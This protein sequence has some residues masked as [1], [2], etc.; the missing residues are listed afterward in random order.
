MCVS[1]T[2]Y[3]NHRDRPDRGSMSLDHAR[4][5]MSTGTDLAGPSVIVGEEESG[6][7]QAVEGPRR[8][9]GEGLGTHDRDDVTALT[10][11]QMELIRCKPPTKSRG[12]GGRAREWPYV[13]EIKSRTVPPVSTFNLHNHCAFP[14]A[15]WS[16]S[17]TPPSPPSIPCSPVL[18]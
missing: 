16:F 18:G 1:R 17:E 6:H 11:S 4:F 7:R 10:E 13:S 3:Q 8:G 12:K 9:L 14:S 2:S 15:L 5:V